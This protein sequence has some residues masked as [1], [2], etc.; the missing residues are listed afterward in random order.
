MGNRKSPFTTGEFFE[1]VMGV[2]KEKGKVPP[3]LDYANATRDVVILDTSDF[4]L[5][6][7]LNF[8]GN[9]GIYLDLS[10]SIY[11]KEDRKYVRSPLG[12]IK[13]LEESEWAFHTMGALAGDFT[14]SAVQYTREHSAD[15]E[16][17]GYS[18]IPFYRDGSKAAYSL[19][20]KDYKAA[21][22]DK[23]NMLVNPNWGCVVIRNN[24]TKDEERFDAPEREGVKFVVGRKYEMTDWFSGGVSLWEVSSI[25]DGK[26]TFSIDRH[27]L[28]GD[29]KCEETHEITKDSMGNEQVVLF[30]YKGEQ[31]VLSACGTYGEY[32]EYEEEPDE[33]EPE[34]VRGKDYYCP[35][36][37]PD[38]NG[39]FHCPF[40]ATGG[41]SCRNHCGQ[42]ADE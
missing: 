34:E 7:A 24:Q 10:I 4:F 30:E 23:D 26:V 12:V 9:E 20:E 27:E 42:G 5:Q 6:Q 14:Y 15:F 39:E 22:S 2:L 19:F 38:E 31:C 32:A 17:V 3:I 16:W 35:C 21:V 37:V 25:D 29:H 13:T 41:D 8:G 11:D 40:G 33:P 28:D 36:D 1:T 18:I